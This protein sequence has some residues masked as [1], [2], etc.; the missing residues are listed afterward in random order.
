[1]DSENKLTEI[2]AW[3]NDKNLR[4]EALELITLLSSISDLKAGKGRLEDSRLRR[5][6]IEQ[7]S[8]I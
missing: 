3:L 6:V 1:M 7:S 8:E 5:K 2:I 4:K